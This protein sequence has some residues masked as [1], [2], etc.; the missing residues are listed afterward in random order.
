MEVQLNCRHTIN[1]EIPIFRADPT[2]VQFVTG[3]FQSFSVCRVKRQHLRTLV[4]F[5]A[6][7]NS[8]A[9]VGG[10]SL[11]NSWVVPRSFWKAAYHKSWS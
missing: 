9:A 6:A 7:K 5:L 2:L 4:I 1:T 11:A 8:Q 10:K 3:I